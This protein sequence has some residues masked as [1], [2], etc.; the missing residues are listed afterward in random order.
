MALNALEYEVPAVALESDVVVMLRTGAAAGVTVTA[1]VPNLVW[2]ATLVAVTVA[3]VL[4][5]TV[6]AVYRPELETVPGD[7]VQVTATFDELLTSAV[8]CFVVPDTTVADEGE[9]VTEIVPAFET[10]T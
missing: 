7:A 2:S 6:G 5:L 9:T 1:A 10:T 8:N 3:L 4:V